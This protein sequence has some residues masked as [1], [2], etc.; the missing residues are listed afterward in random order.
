MTTAAPVTACTAAEE[1]LFALTPNMINQWSNLLQSVIKHY[2][3]TKQTNDKNWLV[4]YQISSSINLV[5]SN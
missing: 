5:T 2:W 3:L 1:H 4:A